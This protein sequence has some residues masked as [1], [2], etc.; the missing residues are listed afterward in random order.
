MFDGVGGVQKEVHYVGHVLPTGRFNEVFEVCKVVV[1]V[2]GVWTK[3]LG[4][5]VVWPKGFGFGVIV[6]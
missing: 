6:L 5:G 2:V 4:V 3:G 1:G